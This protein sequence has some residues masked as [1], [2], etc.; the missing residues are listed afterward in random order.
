MPAAAEPTDNVFPQNSNPHKLFCSRIIWTEST[1]L[2]RTKLLF[3]ILAL[4]SINCFSNVSLYV[5]QQQH[6]P[7]RP[8]FKKVS[9]VSFAVYSC[10]PVCLPPKPELVCCLFLSLCLCVWNQHVTAR[11]VAWSLVWHASLI[12]YQ[13]AS[14]TFASYNDCLTLI[15]LCS[16]SCG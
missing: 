4:F 12:C 5:L 13:T 7:W 11:C 9:W 8:D 2:F 15:S 16:C 1:K 6:W 3:F 14:Q 10:I